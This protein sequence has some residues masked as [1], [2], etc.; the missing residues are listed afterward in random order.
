LLESGESP[1]FDQRATPLGHFASTPPEI[2][3]LSILLAP[4][5]GLGP[6]P[7]IELALY[8]EQVRSTVPTLGKSV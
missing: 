7:P 6:R 2:R 4:W 5:G 8:P 3:W 1:D